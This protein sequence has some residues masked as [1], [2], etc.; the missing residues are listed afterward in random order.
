[1]VMRKS[2]KTTKLFVSKIFL[3]YVINGGF[4]GSWFF[5]G[6]LQ[7]WI[8]FTV[9]GFAWSVNGNRVLYGLNTS[10]T[11]TVYIETYIESHYVGVFCILHAFYRNSTFVAYASLRVK[12]KKLVTFNYGI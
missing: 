6:Q 4:S 2:P 1:M 3:L 7:Q 10:L 9:I 12:G 11:M 5:H 8:D